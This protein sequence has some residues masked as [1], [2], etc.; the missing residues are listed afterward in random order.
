MIPSVSTG[1]SPSAQQLASDRIKATGAP[2]IF[3]ETGASPQLAQQLAQEVGIK[4]VTELFTH[5]IT[6]AKGTAPTYLDMMRYNVK[7]IVQA[8][9]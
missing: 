7:A 4:A 9:K 6:D 8:L 5:S 2:A 1:A 3:L